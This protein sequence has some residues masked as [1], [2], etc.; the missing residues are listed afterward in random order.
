MKK[1]G[2]THNLNDTRTRETTLWEKCL[3]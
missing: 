1:V 2:I 3:S